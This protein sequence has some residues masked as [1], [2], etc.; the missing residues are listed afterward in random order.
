[1]SA[2]SETDREDF[3]G[4][5]KAFLEEARLIT[6]F[7]HP[8]IVHVRRFFEMHGTGYIVLDYERGQT[9][10]R[11]LGGGPIPEA[12]LRGILAGLLDGL[13]A[14]HGRAILHRDLKPSN[15]I[16]RE[17]GTPVLIDFGAARDFAGR[18]S[19]SI[20][21]IAAPG[22]SPPE[23]YGV[24]GQQQGPWTD[25]YSLGAIAYR[26]V[27]GTVPVDSLRRLRKDPLVPAA[28]AAAG[29]YDAALLRT[30]DWML[31][32][33]EGD[34]P[35]SVQAVRAALASGV[36]RTTQRRPLLWAA[37]AA[38][39]VG[40]I[41]IAAA[42]SG[43]GSAITCGQLGLFCPTQATATDPT[44]KSAP[45]SATAVATT[46]VAPAATAVSLSNPS[47][48]LSSD[49]QA[50][51]TPTAQ[52]AD[53]A[54]PPAKAPETSIPLSAAA[55]AWAAT[56]DTTSV[57]VLE[58]YASRYKDTVYGDLANAR[59]GELKKQQTAALTP[60]STSAAPAEGANATGAATAPASASDADAWEKLRDSRDPERW[61]AFLDQN[62]TS[63]HKADA[64]TR[65]AALEPK[66]TDCDTLAANLDDPRKISTIQGVSYWRFDGVAA[67]T[68]CERAVKDF[69]DAPR[70]Q[71]QLGRA[72]NKLKKYD[73]ARKWYAKAADSGY[74]AAMNEMGVLYSAG[75]GVTKD[76]V[77]AR[78]WQTRAA[79]LGY[80]PAMSAMGVLYQYGYGLPKDFDE[81]RKWYLK[82]IA[83]GYSYAMISVGGLYERGEGVPKD[84]DEARRWYLKAA[85]MG[86]ASAMSSLGYLY[87]NGNGVPKDYAEARNWF[88]KAADLDAGFSMDS[89]ASLYKTG[90]PNL[91]QD[92]AE[93]R[94]W[95]AKAANLNNSSAMLELGLLYLSGK[96]VPQDSAEARRWF[97]KI[98]EPWVMNSLG[99][100]YQFG[101]N[102]APKDFA[103]A[104]KWYLKA[105]DLGDTSS[106]WSIGL[107]FENGP[108]VAPDYSE[109]RKW[110]TR[111]A[112]LGNKYAMQRIGALYE[113]GHGVPKDYGEARKWYEKAAAL[114]DWSAMQSLGRMAEDGLGMPRDKREAH[115]WYAKAADAGSTLG[116]NWIGVDYAKGEG[117]QRDCNES[118]KWLSKAA[119]L[120]N[121]QAMYNLG[122][123]Y[124]SGTCVARSYGEARQWYQKAAE[125]GYENAR[126]RLAR[127]RH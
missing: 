54:R 2:K 20:T 88:V 79:D 126:K 65:L 33:E 42:A 93:A 76:Y 89:V 32:L 82:A 108:G 124:E 60:T 23:Q 34:R 43:A 90:G 122:W 75:L 27:T 17:D 91:P 70:L 67:S 87:Q 49:A 39:V 66:V 57:A 4:G 127:L 62:P 97:A 36:P 40:V 56:K 26:C 68:A 72:Y 106:M 25:L 1:M 107:L 77:E 48:A 120:G 116:M 18:N 44:P 5:L 50:S 118:L 41:V 64:T 114:N 69:P 3:A 38:A 58:T 86:N 115:R 83:A 63:S 52:I 80:P 84:L 35:G 11:R 123:S 102:G 28:T 6:R 59:I 98:D 46:P 112:D 81:A 110:Y 103:E 13:E 92:Y 71:Y 7:R 113:N 109:A 78:R 99:S 55:E 73:D 19:R 95:Y 22:Y 119:D 121:T 51:A 47:A 111:A 100:D 85:D 101:M 14:M 31:K 8:N 125:K 117:V 12:E 15:V 21:A 61:R 29:K 9:L 96:G 37:A 74:P 24:G 45:A 94:K 53:T 105:V 104:R 30:I 16:I 10:S